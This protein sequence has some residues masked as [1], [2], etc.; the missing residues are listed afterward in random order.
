M[1]RIAGCSDN[2]FKTFVCQFSVLNAL[3]LDN[4]CH[5]LIIN[6]HKDAEKDNL[7]R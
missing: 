7:Q 3:E 5:L 4:V 2:S 1:S 6:L